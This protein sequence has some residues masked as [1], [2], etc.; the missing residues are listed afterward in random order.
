MKPQKYSALIE[1]S[2]NSATATQ[3]SFTDQPYLRDKKVTGIM[4]SQ[5]LYSWL[6]MLT[7]NDKLK[8]QIASP[9]II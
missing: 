5:A 7:C 1:V 8:I 4:A 3:F 6:A 2:L 9:F